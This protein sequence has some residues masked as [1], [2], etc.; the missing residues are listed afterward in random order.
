MIK[1]KGLSEVKEEMEHKDKKLGERKIDIKK[2]KI[3]KEVQ[4]VRI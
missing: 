1:M 3:I 2:T 4:R